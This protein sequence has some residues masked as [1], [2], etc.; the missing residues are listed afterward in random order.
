MS[1]V[2]KRQNQL[3]KICQSLKAADA[4]IVD[5]IQFGSSVYAPDLARDVD[6]LIT[7]RNKKDEDLYLDAFL[8][9]DIGVDVIVRTPGQVMGKDI[10]A[11][12]FLLGKVLLGNGQTMKEAEGFMAAPT[13]ERA[14]LALESADEILALT[15]KRKKKSLQHEFYCAAFKR[16]FDA[17]RNAVMAYLNTENSRW[18]QLR[19]EL[20]QP[21]DEQFRKIARTLHIQYSYDGNYP[22]DRAD[23]E[24]KDWRQV[25]VNFIDELEAASSR[26]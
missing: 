2:D 16:L 19:K 10:A 13:F 18:G 22:K 11:S 6:L 4:D 26:S 14:R 24:F 9:L 8:E 5:I 12:V 23:D 7:T 17:A 20:P 1:P 3:R 21:F 15:K 25:V